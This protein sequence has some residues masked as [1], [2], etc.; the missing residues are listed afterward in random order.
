[1]IMITNIEI[2]QPRLSVRKSNKKSVGCFWQY[3]Q[4]CQSNKVFPNEL[5][6]REA[7]DIRLVAACSIYSANIISTVIE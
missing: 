1:M 5:D 3:I 7:I 2:Q 6:N 4:I